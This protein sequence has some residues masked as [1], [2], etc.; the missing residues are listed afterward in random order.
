MKQKELVDLMTTLDDAWNAGP[1]GP[2]WE[3]FRKRHT[4]NVAVYWPGG[5]PP[6]RGQHNHDAAAVA[7]FKTFPDNHVVNR[8]HKLPF[9]DGNHMRSVAE[10][11]MPTRLR[12]GKP[13]LRRRGPVQEPLVIHF[14]TPPRIG[15]QDRLPH[16]DQSRDRASPTISIRGRYGRR[17]H[18]TFSFGSGDMLA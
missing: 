13:R 16:D 8:P 10:R 6:T 1:G 7:F 9:S 11:T 14:G 12:G 2:L 15:A 4:E 5:A 18:E 17:S 3:T